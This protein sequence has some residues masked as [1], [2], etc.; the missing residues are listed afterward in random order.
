MAY[1]K[2]E[3]YNQ[4][5]KILEDNKDIMFIEHL[6]SLM[7]CGRTTFY[8]HMPDK[9]DELNTI[10]EYIERNKVERKSKMYKK[11]FDSDHPTLQVALM[12]L[13]STDAEA[14]RL[15]GSSQKVDATNKN[16]IEYVN[17]SKQFP[18]KK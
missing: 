3:L 1:N 8:E 15:N 14:H 13:I 2:E 16:T 17:V 12:K 5:I 9:S 6:V 11:W 10:K 7:P 4:A 18:D